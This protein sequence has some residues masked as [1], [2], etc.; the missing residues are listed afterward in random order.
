MTLKLTAPQKQ[1]LGNLQDGWKCRIHDVDNIETNVEFW[2]CKHYG[3]Y[4]TTFGFKASTFEEIVEQVRLGY[5]N[6]DPEEETLILYEAGRN[7]LKGVPT[8]IRSLLWEMD[9]YE[10][11]LENLYFQFRDFATA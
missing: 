6:F 5:L 7:G 11:E 8:S 4:D 10:S 2:C 9:E 1:F 3:D